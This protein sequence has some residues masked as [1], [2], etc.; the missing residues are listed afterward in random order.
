MD[1]EIQI[2]MENFEW[3]MS[4]HFTKKKPTN[5]TTVLK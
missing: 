4:P 3:Q 5:E 2:Q 1:A